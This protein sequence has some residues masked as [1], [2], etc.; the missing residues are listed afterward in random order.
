MLGILLWE[1]VFEEK[2]GP[3]AEECFFKI[4]ENKNPLKIT[5]Y[6]IAQN[7]GRRKLWQICRLIADLP[8]FYSTMILYKQARVS[9][10]KNCFMWNALLHC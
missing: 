10:N 2:V 3:F 4:S 1:F 5:L 9:I 6:C 8:T 7:I